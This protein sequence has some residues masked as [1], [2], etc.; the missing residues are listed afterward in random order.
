MVVGVGRSAVVS[1]LGVVA[2]GGSGSGVVVGRAEVVGAPVFVFAGQGAQWVGMGRELMASSE[3]F[4]GAMGECAEAL[5]PFVD[6]SLVDVLGDSVMLAR[7]D[8]VQPVLWAV[9]VSL[10]RLWRWVGVEPAAVVGHSQGEIAAACVVGALSLAD[11]ARVVA[12]R[13]RL[14]AGLPPVGAMASVGLSVQRVRVDVAECGGEVSVA[15]VN[16]PSSVV[17]SGVAASVQRLV[18]GWVERGVWARLIPTEVAGH[19]VQVDGVRERLLGELAS[20]VPRRVEVPFYS[21]VD[22]GLVD[23]GGLDAGYWWRNLREPVLFAPTVQVLVGAGFRAFVEVSSHPVVSVGLEE[24]AEGA[25]V[26]VG[27]GVV[28]AS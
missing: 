12:V 1:G 28:V 19:S 16:G 5:A 20:V 14:L 2:S 11:G 9:M 21:T 23:T 26:D 15:A 10:A 25:G 27:G 18:A 6:W 4:A 13:S 24:T 8:V 17:V 7:L 22:G 3:V